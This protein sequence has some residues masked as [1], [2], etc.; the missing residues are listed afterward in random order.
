MCGLADLYRGGRGI[1]L[2]CM[3]A[4]KWYLAAA[5]RGNAAA[6]NNV[7]FL[8]R[9]GEGCVQ[10][11]GEAYK[12]YRAAAEKGIAMSM[13]HLGYL[14]MH[15][16]GVPQDDED[17]ERWFELFERACTVDE[18]FAWGMRYMDAPVGYEAD[19]ASAK[20]WLTLAASKG[21][22]GAAQKLE[23]LN[24]RPS[25]FMDKLKSPRGKKAADK[26]KGDKDKVSRMSVCVC[27]YDDCVCVFVCLFVAG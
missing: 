6:M 14:H 22:T 17:A 2:D 24:R 19:T 20:R 8:F 10:N 7:A 13:H 9:Q 12:W 11:Y 3:E 25:S 27:F 5:E 18:A 26:A 23:E 15:G 4:V 1:P 16:L 21:H